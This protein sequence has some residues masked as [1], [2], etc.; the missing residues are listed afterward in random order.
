[1]LSRSVVF[2]S[3]WLHGLQPARLLC[4]WGFPRQEEWS[5]LPCCLPGDLPNPG[6]KPRSPILQEDSLPSELPGKPKNTGVGTR[7]LLQGSLM[8]QESNQGLLHCRWILYQLSYQVSKMPKQ[9]LKKKKKKKNRMLL[10]VLTFYCIAQFYFSLSNISLLP[11]C[12][13]F[14]F[15]FVPTCCLVA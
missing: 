13:I 10:R 1:M 9:S 12:Y 14:I 8:S 3:L 7:S 15:L 11:M 6:I 4:P 5:G 2:S